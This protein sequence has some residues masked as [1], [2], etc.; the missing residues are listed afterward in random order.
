MAIFNTGGFTG[1]VPAIYDRYLGP[2]LFEPYAVDLA[3]RLRDLRRGRLL[4][5]AAGTGIVTRTV[6]STLS[7][8]VEIVATDLSPQMLDF[9]ASKLSESRVTWQQADAEALPFA[10]NEFDA[11]ICQFGVMYFLDQ[12][13]AYREARRVLKPGGRLLF[14]VWG[15]LDNNEFTL[16]VAEAVSALFPEDPPRFF[17]RIPFAYRG[18]GEIAAA[19]EAAGFG[20]F[21]MDTVEQRSLAASPRHAAI[22]LCQGMPIRNE[23][24]A[25]DPS[26]LDEATDAATAALARR[27]GDGPIEGRMQAIV[28][29]AV[30]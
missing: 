28:V 23:I 9:A 24:E 19:L 4:E 21:Q 17:A 26:L 15:S 29:E 25:R 10:D 8:A 2:M 5:L 1:P 27:F 16:V 12:A 13:A 7:E 14:N 22:G 3:V 20:R 18:A 30:K 11:V 6:A